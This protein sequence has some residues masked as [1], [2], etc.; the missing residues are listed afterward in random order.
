[1]KQKSVLFLRALYVISL[2]LALPLNLLSQEKYINPADPQFRQQYDSMVFGD[3]FVLLAESDQTNNY[4]IA[5]FS[6]FSSKFEKVYFLSLVFPSKNVV[7]IDGDLSH[8]RIWFLA[9]KKYSSEE[10]IKELLEDKEKSISFA[11]SLTEDE[12][13][14]WLKTNDKYK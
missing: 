13:N 5:D 8:D 9:N 14:N 4:F 6:K 11:A 1:M 3:K 7:N 10:V 12:K 2:V